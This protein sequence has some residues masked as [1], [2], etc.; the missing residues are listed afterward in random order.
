VEDRNVFVG[1]CKWWSGPSSFASPDKE[2]PSA[3][4]QL[5]SYATW[6][7]AKLALTVFV[8]NKDVGKVIASAREALEKH[9]AFIQW[10]DASDEGQLRCRV[11]LPGNDGRS[12]DLALIF[13]HLPKD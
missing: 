9:P 7:D 5:L 10:I 4:N 13:V 11:R 3:L 6:R 8:D 12:A 2:E 1:E